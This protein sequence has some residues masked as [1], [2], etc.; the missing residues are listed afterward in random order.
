[1]GLYSQ[2]QRGDKTYYVRPV[3]PRPRLTEQQQGWFP[4]V[5]QSYM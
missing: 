2:W 1:M 4:V 5:D 3:I